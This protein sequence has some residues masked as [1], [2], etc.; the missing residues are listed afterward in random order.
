PAIGQ[1]TSPRKW[2]T[3]YVLPYGR[4]SL[5]ALAVACRRSQI[6]TPLDRTGANTRGPRGPG[7][8]S[9]R[10]ERFAGNERLEQRS[11]AFDDT[12]ATYLPAGWNGPR[13][14]NGNGFSPVP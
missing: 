14:P 6:L 3:A 5:S 13:K 7:S 10:L 2:V 11:R 8:L 1:T 4:V 9:R 12:V